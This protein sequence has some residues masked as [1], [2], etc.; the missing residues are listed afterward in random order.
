MTRWR[1]GKCPIVTTLITAVL[2]LVAQCFPKRLILNRTGSVPRGIYWL[3]SDAAIERGSI[4]KFP[5]PDSVR[6]LV[7]ERRLVPRGEFFDSF[8]KPVAAL[9][10]E[11]VC[12]RDH[13][14][15]INEARFAPVP[16]TDSVGRELPRQQFCR[17]LE[18]GEVFVAT[19]M[20]SFDS[21]Y[22]GPIRRDVIR[23]V[24]RPLLTW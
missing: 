23:G 6:E 22:Y 8:S 21:R 15:W 19:T 24:I 1:H 7:F 4:V 3:S 2:L 17:T 13:A 10:G 12:I 18:D 9:P 11:R 5:I 20:L 14:L 16:A